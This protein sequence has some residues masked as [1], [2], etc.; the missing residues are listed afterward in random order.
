VG[1]ATLA[2]TGTW[3]LNQPF[4]NRWVVRKL[5][6]FVLDQTGLPFTAEHLELDLRGRMV[7]RGFTLGGDLLQADRLEVQVDFPSLLQSRKHVWA[8]RLDRPRLVVDKAALARIH[9]KP[10]PESKDKVLVK[11][12]HLWIGGGRLLL[13]EPAWGLPEGAFRFEVKANGLGFNRMLANLEIPEA[14]LRLQNGSAEGRLG[15]LVDLAEERI[16]VKKAEIQL[17]PAYLKAMGLLE[18]TS[19]RFEL[20]VDGRTEVARTISLAS[21]ENP[22]VQ[23]Q[24][25]FKAQG[26]GT[27]SQP[28]WSLD[29]QAPEIMPRSGPFH[30]G[31]LRVQAKG[32]LDRATVQSIRWE[33]Q[34]A[35]LE[36]KGAWS[37]GR[38]SQLSL[39]LEN[40]D[41][42][43]LATL[44]R[45]DSLKDLRG[46]FQGDIEIPGDPWA[47]PRWDKVS[48]KA[49]GALDRFGAPMGDLD[50]EVANGQVDLRNFHLRLDA[51]QIDGTA[52]ARLERRGL[53]SLEAKGFVFTDAARVADALTAW[54]VVDLDMAGY[55]QAT[56]DEVRWTRQEGLLLLGKV[57]VT[58]PRWHEASADRL[59]GGVQIHGDRLT[60]TQIVADRAEGK[61]FGELWLTWGEVVPGADQIDMCY[62][63]HRLPVRQ[64][65]AAADL[66][67]PL[68][69]IA[70]GWSRI[71]GPFDRLLIDGQ[72]L[73]EDGRAYGLTLPAVSGG[74]HLDLEGNRLT[75]PEF[76]IASTL[77]QLDP[78][79]DQP[80]GPLALLGS[81]DMDLQKET[82]QGHLGG[83]VDTEALGLGGPRIQ[84]QLTGR[85]EG[86]WTSPFG[87]W[88]LPE[89]S[90][91]VRRGRAFLGDQ[92]LEDL[93]AA[94]D[95][96]DGHLTAM[97]G[98]Q[99]RRERILGLEAFSDGGAVLGTVQVIAD[100]DQSAAPSPE[101]GGSLDTGGLALRSTHDLLEN[102]AFR[103]HAQGVWTREG[104]TWNGVIEKLQARF[105]GFD[106]Q[107]SRPSLLKGT[108]A[109]ANLD[110]NLL[111]ISRAK[112]QEAVQ[113]PGQAELHLTGQIPFS[114][115]GRL[116]LRAEGQA[117]VANLKGML[118]LFLDVDENSL[119]AELRPEGHA[120]VDLRVQG[121]YATPS[122]D[123]IAELSRGRLK[124]RTYPQSIEDLAFRVVFK[125]QDILLPAEAPLLGRLAQGALRASGKA[126]WQSGGLASYDVSASLQEFQLH[127]IPGLEGLDMNGRLEARLSGNDQEGGLLKGTLEADHVV[128]KAD[129]RLTDL[130]LNNSLA[131]SGGVSVDDPF[132]RI[133]LDLDLKLKQPW[134]F[135]TNLLKVEGRP[136]GVFK[137]QGNLLNPGLKGKMLL[138]GGGRVTNLL[139]AG[140]IV[141]ERGELDFTDPYRVNPVFN[142]Q[143]RVDVP[144]YQVNLTFNGNLD[145]FNFT[146]T[147]TPSLRQA[148]VL[149]ILVDPTLAP[150]IGSG[151]SQST[152]NYGIASAGA[153]ILSSAALAAFQEGLRK[154]F[155]LDRLNVAFRS[156]TGLT[157]TNINAGK[158]VPVLSRTGILF[159]TY[160]RV[161]N[162][163]TLGGQL[164]WAMGNW[165]IQLGASGSDS[166]D[167]NPT[168]E[169]RYSWSPR[170]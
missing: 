166:A 8:I 65:L 150:T 119:L 7:L 124:I 15:F 146:S 167:I 44:T 19:N 87:P 52:K 155:N 110:L 113:V 54:K 91:A 72:A 78:E 96:R 157:E 49:T 118:D 139:P 2:W 81:L 84:A 56:A 143:G 23:G 106:M 77:G 29:L 133:S 160:R 22:F 92:S 105:P 170:R 32:S 68:S 101:A 30:P 5:A 80:S 93:E 120:R 53:E 134:L 132:A 18:P 63:A 90:V 144:P 82:W 67:L 159:G 135:D 59:T 164:E 58:G 125:G 79:L 117:Q 6:D 108:L 40:L 142:L 20:Q 165:V 39:S 114:N 97:L 1:G 168:G 149:A 57:D 136:E 122:L 151:T 37:R 89:G 31:R 43:P 94:L 16:Q 75:V 60:A 11:V 74:F 76:R 129:L 26:E 115:Q 42:D 12:D 169:I 158:T 130:L 111:G 112:D 126:T 10:R 71:H 128:Y 109:G 61:A 50:L 69:G 123:G 13:R 85:L 148:E 73:V 145:Q 121:T 47:L 153:G 137:V 25:S 163:V 140:D 131:S 62:R 127:D 51:L 98:V 46:V 70:S 41:L 83:A 162:L 88:P 34:D 107:Q 17:G 154:T 24:V 138:L 103:A 4:S 152:L 156:S 3:V 36:L 100:G 141:L 21:G 27:L 161:G 147:S 116:D 66:D 28:T 102:G 35:V 48:L 38:S 45:V 86:P 33:S 95:L 55:V 14:K 99:G 64:G 104:L 9:L